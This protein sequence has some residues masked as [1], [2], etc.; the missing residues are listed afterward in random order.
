MK[1]SVIHYGAFRS[2]GSKSDLDISP[3]VTIGAVRKLLCNHLGQDY[4]LLIDDSVFA[5][6]TDV[7]PD[8]FVLDVD[9]S[10]SILPPVC[11]G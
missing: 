5:N 9:C 4:A 6:D 11:G 10:L 8:E 3:P 7:L 1:V 2:L